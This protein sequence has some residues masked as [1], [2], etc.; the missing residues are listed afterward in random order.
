MPI[1]VSSSTRS[2]A[3]R[4]LRAFELAMKTPRAWSVPSTVV[5]YPCSC[6]IGNSLTWDAATASRFKPDRSS[7]MTWGFGRKQF[8]LPWSWRSDLWVFQAH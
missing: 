6:N 2:G 3:S 5:S 1:V 4:S 7:A 8:Q